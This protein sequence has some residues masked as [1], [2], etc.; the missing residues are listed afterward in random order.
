MINTRYS[1]T[2]GVACKLRGWVKVGFDI[3]LYN[4]KNEKIG[5]IELSYKLHKAIFSE[6]TNWSSYLYLRRIRD[7]YDTDIILEKKQL[8]LFLNDLQIISKKIIDYNLNKELA[9]IIGILEDLSV[10]KIHIASD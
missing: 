1:K 6:A 3:V 4:K 9:E 7:Y 2:L 10:E 8:S 5:L